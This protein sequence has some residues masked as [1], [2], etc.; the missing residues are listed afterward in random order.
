[1]TKKELAEKLNGRQYGDSFEDVAGRGKAG[2]LCY[3]D[4]CFG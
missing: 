1:M 3:C 2:R 4:R